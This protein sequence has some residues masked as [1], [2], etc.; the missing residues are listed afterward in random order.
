MISD[1]ISILVISDDIT[2]RNILMTS[3]GGNGYSIHTTVDEPT[4]LRLVQ[5]S[6]WHIIFLDVK[7][8]G[9]DYRELHQLICATDATPIL[10]SITDQARIDPDIQEFD[11]EAFDYITKP[12]DPNRLS[13]VFSNA[14]GF[15][16]LRCENIKLKERIAELTPVHKNSD[17]VALLSLADI[18][19]AHITDILEQ[20]RWN[21]SRSAA[22]LHVDRVTLYNKIKKYGLKRSR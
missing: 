10:I 8:P 13:H 16:T 7:K 3:L 4:A 1:Q 9:M 6:K 15:R 20:N 21:I 5:N 18:E 14:I 17:P 2:V 22:I 11:I 12:I 19:R